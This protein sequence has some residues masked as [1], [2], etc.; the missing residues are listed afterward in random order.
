MGEVESDLVRSWFSAVLSEKEA[1]LGLR[2]SKLV[3]S[4][5]KALLV[6]MLRVLLSIAL[7]I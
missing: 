1:A 7:A 2:W 5:P 4:L 3:M 6:G